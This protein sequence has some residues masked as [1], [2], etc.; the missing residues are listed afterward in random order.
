MLAYA[1]VCWRMQVKD[2]GE[3]K[4]L[5]IK[6]YPWWPGVVV[7]MSEVPPSQKAQV[8]SACVGVGV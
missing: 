2:K 7:S 6:G 5:R 3:I 8:L 1:G 4:W